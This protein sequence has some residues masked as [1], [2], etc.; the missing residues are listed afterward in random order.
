MLRWCAHP[1]N[2]RLGG[3]LTRASGSAG[4]RGGPGWCD[5]PGQRGTRRTDR[6]S[7][8]RNTA[9]AFLAPRQRD[10]T[11]DLNR[12]PYRH[13]WVARHSHRD[14]IPTRGVQRHHLDLPQRQTRLPIH[15]WLARIECDPRLRRPR[16]HKRHPPYQSAVSSICP[17]CRR[18]A[19]ARPHSPLQ[20]D[21]LDIPRAS[22]GRTG[23]IG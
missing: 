4:V 9:A 10:Q 19:T 3:G 15:P 22:T 13:I 16:A 20:R 17:S 18:L 12:L 11:I 14:D 6:I 1:S 21:K 8:E 23:Q 7:P 2:S 5:D